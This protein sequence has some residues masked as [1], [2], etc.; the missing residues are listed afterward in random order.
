[1]GLAECLG[2]PAIS[3]GQIF[4]ANMADRTEL[5]M[6]VERYM[7]AGEFVPDAVTNPLV[8]LRLSA[9]DAAGGFV[10][11]GYPRSLEQAHALRDVLAA[12]R[13][14]LDVVLEL[15]APKEKLIERLMHRAACEHR[16]DDT[17]EIFGH[18]LDMYHQ[19]TE[20]LATYYAEQD[21]LEVVDASGTAEQVHQAMMD[22]LREH[23]LA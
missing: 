23:S 2:V 3:T 20:P 10:L 15:T 14:Q 22:V 18:R 5:G 13:I 1:M 21:L 11:D 4:R 19:R 7:N 12:E 6:M 9:P 16:S 8:A 17:A